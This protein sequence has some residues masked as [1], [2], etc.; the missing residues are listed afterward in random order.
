MRQRRKGGWGRDR[1]DPTEMGKGLRLGLE[2]LTQREETKGGATCRWRGT[3]SLVRGLGKQIREEALAG[4][5]R[6]EPSPLA[7]GD[8]GGGAVSI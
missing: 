3:V 8:G 4:G 2:G 5:G 6:S 1:T 7:G